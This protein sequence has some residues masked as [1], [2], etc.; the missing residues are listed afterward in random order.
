MSIFKEIRIF[1]F[2]FTLS[3]VF[4]M[5]VWADEDKEDA[6]LSSTLYAQTA[7][8]N[9]YVKECGSCHF[10]YPPALL[11]AR[12]WTAIMGSLDKHFGENAE[13][14]PEQQAAISAYLTEQAADKTASRLGSG[15]LKS[16]PAS[17]APLRI[18]ETP[19]FKRKH[20]EIPAKMVVDN[21]EVKSFSRCNV[22]HQT[23]DKGIFNEDNVDIPNYGR[24]ED[25]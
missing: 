22:C 17:A 4:N 20:D 6:R 1:F 11:P 25:D 5:P 2:C 18:T 23:A 16:L 24:W 9:D 15:F 12:S 7:L 3:T 21:P 14:L 19:Y 8:N 10:A 13:L